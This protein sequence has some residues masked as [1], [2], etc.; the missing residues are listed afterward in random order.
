MQGRLVLEVIDQETQEVVAEAHFPL[1]EKVV[2]IRRVPM[3]EA[4]SSKSASSESD[5][6]GP[7]VGE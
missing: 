4:M 6:R 5:S 7:Y 1:S 3:Y 2:K